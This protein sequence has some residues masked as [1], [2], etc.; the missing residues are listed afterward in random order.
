M[1]NHFP[2]VSGSLVLARIGY[3]LN[4]SAASIPTTPSGASPLSFT[5]VAASTLGSDVVK[6]FTLSFSFIS[7][8]NFGSFDQTVAETIIA[9]MATGYLN[10]I[11]GASG[12]PLTTLQSQTI[13]ERQWVWTGSGG[14]TLTMSDTMVYP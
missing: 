5:G 4:F 9:Q 7:P 13:I 2:Q 10:V 3:V 8:G 14:Y 1:S 6:T 11:A 12:I